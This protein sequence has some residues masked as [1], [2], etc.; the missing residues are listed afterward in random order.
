MDEQEFTLDEIMKEF[1]SEESEPSSEETVLPDV[2][3][4]TPVQ[5]EP[6]SEEP[7]VQEAS[8]VG[9]DTIRMDAV[10]FT[11]GEVHNAQPIDDE[12]EQPAA[13]IQ[14]EEQTEPFSEEWEPDY[15]Q[16]IAEY[17]P[18]QPIIFHPRSKMRELKRKLVQGPEKQYYML[19]ELGLG[20][21][22]AAIFFTGL[23]ALISAAAT[24]MFALGFVQPERTKLMVFAQF[25]AMLVSALLG[26]FQLI[27]GIADLK[28]KRFSLNTLLVFTF[29]L[30]CADG[31]MG[32]YEQRV[33]C[34]AAFSLQMTMSLWN[35]YQKRNTALGQL[36]TMRKA[37]NLHGI[38]R[39]EDY[40]EETPALLRSEGQVEDF[41]DSYRA[42]SPM[43]KT[44]SIYALVALG[45]SLAAGII[46]GVL[47]G[48]TLGIQV[49]AVTAL[50]AMP[51][52]MFIMLSRPMSILERRLHE[53]GAVICGWRGIEGM[54]GKILFPV[55][56]EDLFPTGSVKLNGVK[57]YGQRDSDQVVAYCTALV[58]ADNGALVPI[59]EHL[60]ESRN[61]LHYHVE[62]YTAYTGGV[63]GAI[64]DEDVL[65]GTLSFLKEMNVDVPEGI[66]VSHAI[67]ISINGELCGLFALAF[68]K[69]RS[70]ATGLG[71][72]SSYRQLHPVI[73]T[74]DF[75][76]TES[77]IREKFSVNTKRIV[78]PGFSERPELRKKQPAEGAPTLAISTSDNLAGLAYCVTGARATRSAAKTGLLVHMIGGI[79]GMV[80]MLVLA[81]LGAQEYL[82]PANLFLYQ[83]I[84]MIPGLLIT[85]WTRSI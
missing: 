84:W 83:L 64:Q 49:A 42:G 37:T 31:I 61:G 43:D 68:D 71:T 36:D 67:G 79:L 17:V 53:L 20:K 65:V 48:L 77:F 1:G 72:L 2:A 57:F 38:A 9:G 54:S 12:D 35:A 23:V 45:V 63:G 40:L 6:V 62:N 13:P 19:S 60:L 73:A 55:S 39:C 56:H 70:A 69:V 34:C 8:F 52:S 82:T 29:I 25:L 18:P 85:E 28:N 47:H 14:P 44:I 41:M 66:R 33:P 32:L 30:C 15:E 51:A 16:P 22:Q 78:F 11:T 27:E 24:I 21:I 7:P 76:L 50:A 3:E 5:E 75:I 58:C 46:A 80:M 74:G 81:V 26:S 10:K 4:E 59:F